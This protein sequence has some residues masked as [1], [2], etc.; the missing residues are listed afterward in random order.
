MT[1]C[2]GERRGLYHAATP[3]GLPYGAPQFQRGQGHMTKVRRLHCRAGGG[4]QKPICVE[5][6]ALRRWICR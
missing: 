4:R 3:H 5:S 6:C 1:V 2:G